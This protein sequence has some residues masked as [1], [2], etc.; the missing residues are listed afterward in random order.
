MNPMKRRH[1]TY[2]A[3]VVLL[4]IFTP[5]GHAQQRTSGAWRDPAKHKVGFVAVDKDVRLEIRTGS[6]RDSRVHP[7]AALRSYDE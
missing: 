5:A 3:V 2:A 6:A 7:R 4:G 1:R